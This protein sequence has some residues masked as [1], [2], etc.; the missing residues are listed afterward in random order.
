MHRGGC[1][2]H[3]VAVVAGSADHTSQAWALQS[4]LAE[5]KFHRLSWAL[6]IRAS[7]IGAVPQVRYDRAVRGVP[8]AF[9]VPGLPRSSSV[10]V[11]QSR[12][13]PCWT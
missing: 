9:F 10:S 4:V 3:R 11:D 8:F 12:V 13:S 2:V 7:A 5:W 1:L 6:L